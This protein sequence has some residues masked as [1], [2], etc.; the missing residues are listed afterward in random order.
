M[1]LRRL[2][3]PRGRA[4]APQ[5]GVP[6]RAD[7]LERVCEG[8]LVAI[9]EP[10][11][12]S[13]PRALAHR[14]QRRAGE[15]LAQQRRVASSKS[16]SASAVA[17]GSHSS[18]LTPCSTSD[19]GPPR[20]ARSRAA[21][22]PAPRGSPGRRCRCALGNRKMSALAYAR[23]SSS[24]SSQPRKLARSPRRSRRRSCSGPPPAS[25][26]CR[27]GS[28]AR[29]SRNASASSSAPFSRVI[30][31]EYSTLTRPRQRRAARA[32]RVEALGVHAAVP[33]Q[34]VAR[35]ATPIAAR[36]SSEAGLGERTTSQAP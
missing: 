24:P 2:L 9:R 17:S 1:A 12:R 18:P 8:P 30:R 4:P 21:R 34:H 31:P 10:L 36:A 25:T 33:A 32:G 14:A 23:A 28:R 29:A 20:R 26:R 7:A 22:S 27:R 35:A 11:Q 15:A 19:S 13:L 5:L 3:R 6:R 16:A